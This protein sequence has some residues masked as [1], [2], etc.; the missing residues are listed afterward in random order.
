MISVMFLNIEEEEEKLFSIHNRG[1]SLESV[2]K[3]RA[4]HFKVDIFFPF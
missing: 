1:D 2:L 3:I 4:G